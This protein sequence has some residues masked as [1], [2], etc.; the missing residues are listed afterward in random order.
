MLGMY[1]APAAPTPGFHAAQAGLQLLI[2]FISI[3]YSDYKHALPY[4]ALQ[5]V[6]TLFHLPYLNFLTTIYTILQRGGGYGNW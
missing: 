6:K 2:L 1:F 4:L 5:L 3:T